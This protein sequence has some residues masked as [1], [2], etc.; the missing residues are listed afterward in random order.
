MRYFSLHMLRYTY[1]Q[2]SSIL[3]S[4]A[5]SCLP[6][7]YKQPK[8]KRRPLS[9]PFTQPVFTI[10][11]PYTWDSVRNKTNRSSAQMSNYNAVPWEITNISQNFLFKLIFGKKRADPKRIIECRGFQ[12]KKLQ[13]YFISVTRYFITEMYMFH[14]N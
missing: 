5:P 13:G 11:L 3:W 6:D 10:R 2:N 12:E 1:L 4:W 7:G 14:L 9:F 8:C